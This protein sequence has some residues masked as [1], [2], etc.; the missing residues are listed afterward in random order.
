MSGTRIISII[1]TQ[2]TSPCFCK[3]SPLQLCSNIHSHMT[4]CSAGSSSQAT[5]QQVIN[6]CLLE[7]TRVHN[8]WHNKKAYFDVTNSLSPNIQLNSLESIISRGL[9]TTMLVSATTNGYWWH[10]QHHLRT[11]LETLPCLQLKLWN[12][13]HGSKVLNPLCQDGMYCR[14]LGEHWEE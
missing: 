14:L 8:T 10:T 13:Q 11:V 3:F 5:F 1:S 2:I 7:T 12:P 9:G 6:K 4:F